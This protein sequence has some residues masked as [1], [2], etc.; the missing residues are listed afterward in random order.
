MF[1]HCSPFFISFTLS[2]SEWSS[3]ATDLRRLCLKVLEDIELLFSSDLEGA[4]CK[5]QTGQHNSSQPFWDYSI[6]SWD[7]L[8]KENAHFFFV[9]FVRCS[10]NGR[11]FDIELWNSKISD[12]VILILVHFFCMI[13]TLGVELSV[14]DVL[15]SLYKRKQEVSLR[16]HWICLEC[17]CNLKVLRK[18]IALI[19]FSALMD[20]VLNML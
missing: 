8:V 3:Y 18:L 16:R 4:E 17:L 9:L 5:R 15:C 20:N 7:F 11:I 19:C 2:R 12:F 6:D 10:K 1:H 13:T 14:F